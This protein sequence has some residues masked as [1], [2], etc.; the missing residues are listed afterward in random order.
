MSKTISGR[1]TPIR[2]KPFPEWPMFGEEEERQVLEVLRSGQWGGHC[3]IKLPEFEEKFAAAHDAKYATACVNGTL[4]ITTALRAAGVEAGDEV[5]IPSYTF[6]ATAT[7]CLM[8]GAIPVFVDVEKDALLIDPEKVE[9]AITNK[10]KAIIAVHIAGAPANMTRLKEIADKHGLKLVEDAA[11]AVGAKWEDRSVGAI[12]DLGAFSFQTS[13][14]ITA[15]EGGIVLTNDAALS[16]KVWSIVNVGRVRDGA[17]YQHERIGWNLRRTG[18]Q[19]AVLLAQLSRLEEQCEKRE[20]NAKYLTDH[21]QKIN[22]I[23]V[24]K[25][26]PRITRHAYH[27]YMFRIAPDLADHVDKKDIIKKLNAE[28]IPVTAGY[29]SLNQN[30]AI[31]DEIEKLTNKKQSTSCPVS[32]R[33]CD[34]EVLWLKQHVLLG[35]RSDMDDIAAAVEKVLKSY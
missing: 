25:H 10:T 4:A 6:I 24:M 18:F 14:N 20:T 31:I 9:E 27:I 17:W 19:A 16:D 23:R 2:K 5:I 22:G 1:D 7:A 33:A 29:V 13:K 3:R 35:D 21:L 11:Q 32:E 26:D 28:G 8:F 34:K 12:G 30:K 15:G